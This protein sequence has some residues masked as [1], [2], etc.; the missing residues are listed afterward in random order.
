MIDHTDMEM[1]RVS[2]EGVLRQDG[3]WFCFVPYR[4]HPYLGGMTKLSLSPDACY[5]HLRFMVGRPVLFV[6]TK[7]DATQIVDKESGKCFEN[8]GSGWFEEGPQSSFDQRQRRWK[9]WYEA[10]RNGSPGD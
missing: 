10:H 5:D 1:S 7:F 4:A 6:K 8:T 2:I 9:S 3:R